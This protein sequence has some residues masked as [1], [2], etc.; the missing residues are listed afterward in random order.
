MGIAM[1]CPVEAQAFG[2]GEKSVG[3]M[4]G[5]ASHNESGYVAMN[6]QWEFAKHFRLVPEV[7]AVFSH[8]GETGFTLSADMHFPFQLVR[9][10]GVY[11]LAGLTFNNW[12]LDEESPIDGNNISRFGVDFGA[13]FDVYFTRYLKL[14][15][16]AKYSLMADTHGCFIGL[17]LGYVF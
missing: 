3:V 8:K 1:M 6:F 10:F 7:G 2:K 9:G 4:G 12:H 16:Q 17:G 15:V 14:N 13:G 11:P 5:Y